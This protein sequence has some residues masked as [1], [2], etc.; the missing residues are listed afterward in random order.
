MKIQKFKTLLALSALLPLIIVASPIS[1][2]DELTLRVNDAIAEPGGLAA[3]VVRTYSSRGVSSGQ[4]CMEAGSVS[5][6]SGGGGAGP[7]ST[8]EKVKVYSTRKD[9]LTDAD[10]EAGSNNSVVLL[11]FISDSAS[12]NRTDGP[13]A[14]YF[15]RV[16]DDVQ[17]GQKFRVSIDRRNTM[18]IGRNGNVI[19]IRPRSGDL[20]IRSKG[21]PYL[22]EAEGDKIA[23]G[24]VAEL[25][26]ETFEP[27]AIAKASIGFRYDPAL[28]AS[29]PRVKLKKKHG[30]RRFSV[31]RSEPGLLLIDVRSPNGKWNTVPGEIVSITYRTPR[32]TSIGQRSRVWLDDS[33]T[34]FV[35]PDDDVLPYRLKGGRLRFE[36]DSSGGGGGGN[37]DNG[38]DDD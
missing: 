1:A 15:F 26:V 7:F 36:S 37:D 14:V 6:P 35:D 18:I 32:N 9:A 21:A 16:R 8:L 2:K 27:V 34:F 12:I 31:D 3:I 30:K 29:R 23:P 25:G 17:P 13:L 19:P 38:S 24:E 20:K 11:Q 5:G 4:I 33:L 22:A 28:A 10:F